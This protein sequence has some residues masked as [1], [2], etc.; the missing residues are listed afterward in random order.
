M[1]QLTTAEM[2]A[3][4]RVRAAIL[5]L[6]GGAARTWGHDRDGRPD[7]RRGHDGRLWRIWP[8]LL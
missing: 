2:S 1:S 7:A 5:R 8:A 4:G 3:G 6:I